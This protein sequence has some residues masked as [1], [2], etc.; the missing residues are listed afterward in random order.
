MKTPILSLTFLMSIFCE[1]LHAQNFTITD[2]GPYNVSNLLNASINNA[3]QVAF[4]LNVAG[5]NHAMFWSNGNLQDLNSL[6]SGSVARGISDVGKI[7]G[8]VT[9]GS[10]GYHA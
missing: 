6:S 9:S 4:T 10:N 1:G 8:S 3:G 7:V 2:I 5:D